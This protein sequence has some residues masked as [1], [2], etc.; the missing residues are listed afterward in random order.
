MGKGSGAL[1][2]E[3]F[4][5]PGGAEQRRESRV[6]MRRVIDVLPCSSRDKWTFVPVEL[7]DCSLSG[8]GFE[9]GQAMQPGEQFLAKLL[10]RGQVR[11][12]V[13]TVRHCRPAGRCF[14]V[15]AEF[16]GYIASPSEEDPHQV[17]A[18]L[19]TGDA[20]GPAPAPAHAP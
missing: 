11:M 8:I 15:G 5:P 2:I 18:Q 10:L 16:S 6:V 17:L 13:Y 1:T 4:A 20:A 3:D 19:L 9:S 14:A 7:T 12:L